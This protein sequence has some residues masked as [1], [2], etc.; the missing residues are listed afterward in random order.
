MPTPLNGDADDDATAARALIPP[1]LADRFVALP[2]RVPPK[3][4]PKDPPNDPP[5]DPPRDPPSDPPM[6]P[7]SDPPKECAA[8]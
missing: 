3:D 4:P 7:P 6:D 1:R 8:V 5:S 2:G